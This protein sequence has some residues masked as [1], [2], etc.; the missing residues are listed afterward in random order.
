[1]ERYSEGNESFWV[2]KELDMEHPEVKEF[3]NYITPKIN[4]CIE[5]AS[6]EIVIGNN[7]KAFF[8]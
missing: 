5:D 8:Y 4:K 7:Q 1:M 3:I 2:A 6:K